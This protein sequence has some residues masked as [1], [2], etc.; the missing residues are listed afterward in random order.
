M[1]DTRTRL[2]KGKGKVCPEG[3]RPVLKVCTVC[4]VE[5]VEE[6][7]PIDE[8]RRGGKHHRCKECHKEGELVRRRARGASP[9]RGRKARGR[10]SFPDIFF[11]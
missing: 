3:D 11:K 6:D 5:K 10:W 2:E 9:V 7:F 8:F 4:R 1:E